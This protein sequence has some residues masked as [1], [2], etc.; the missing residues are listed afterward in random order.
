MCSVSGVSDGISMKFHFESL[1]CSESGARGA[2]AEMEM[3]DEM[4]LKRYHI[5]PKLM[6]IECINHSAHEFH[7][8]FLQIYIN[9]KT[10][11]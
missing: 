1:F 11:W 10:M 2:R 3:K 9:M 5:P 4:I 8:T 6:L 7:H